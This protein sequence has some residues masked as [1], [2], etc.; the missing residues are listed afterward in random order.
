VDIRVQVDPN[1]GNERTAIITVT[2]NGNAGQMTVRINQAAKTAGL[3]I[4]PETQASG[5]N[6]G[7]INFEVTKTGYATIN[8]ATEVTSG[9]TWAHLTTGTTGSNDGVIGVEIDTNT[10]APRTAIITVKSTD[11]SVG[12]KILIINQDISNGINVV[13]TA[14]K[15]NVYPNPVV[16]QCTVKMESFDGTSRKLEVFNMMGQLETSQVLNQESTIVDLSS[17]PQG[18]YMFRVTEDNKILSQKRVVKN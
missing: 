7:D 16:N 11:P 2:A 14:S 13:N 17:L 1:S 10:G 8:W 3:D 12:T 9:A 5:F 15:L 4:A 18:I 6:G